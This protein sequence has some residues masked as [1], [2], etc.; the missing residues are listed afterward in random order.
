MSEEFMNNPMMR[1]QMK[2]KELQEEIMTIKSEG[3]AGDG[4][5]KVIFAGGTGFE[6]VKI[7]PAVVSPNSR[8][9][10]EE[11]LLTA[12]RSAVEEVLTRVQAKTMEL[13]KELGLS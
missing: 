11:M 6:S 2:M 13:H 1:L 10:L 12:S 7:D 5:V 3:T 9:Q 8:K 4:A